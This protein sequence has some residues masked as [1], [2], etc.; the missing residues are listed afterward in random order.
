MYTSVFPFQQRC[1]VYFLNQIVN[2]GWGKTEKQQP[3][4]VERR[5]RIVGL[6]PTK[7]ITFF[8]SLWCCSSVYRA[9]NTPFP[10]TSLGSNVSV[11]SPY[12]DVMVV[13]ALY[14]AFSSFEICFNLVFNSKGSRNWSHVLIRAFHLLK[15]IQVTLYQILLQKASEN[16]SAESVVLWSSSS[17]SMIEIQSTESLGTHKHPHITLI[18]SVPLKTD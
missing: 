5:M 16:S 10:L 6:G 1:L 2:R 14:L 12:V 9:S 3:K 17:I 4:M 8:P 18:Q 13:V 7:H 15:S 11:R